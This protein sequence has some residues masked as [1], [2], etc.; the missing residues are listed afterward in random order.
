MNKRQTKKLF[1]QLCL[2]YGPRISETYDDGRMTKAETK[3][4]KQSL[5]NFKVVLRLAS[6]I[7]RTGSSHKYNFKSESEYEQRLTQYLVKQFNTIAIEV[8]PHSINT[9]SIQRGNNPPDKFSMS[10]TSLITGETKVIY[11]EEGVHE[12][13]SK[14]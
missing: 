9:V 10:A 13:A 6:F 8:E 4:V 3:R 14:R 11:Q 5:S 1:K 2:K 12:I 7:K